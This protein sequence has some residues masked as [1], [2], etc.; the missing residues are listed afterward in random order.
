MFQKF[1]ELVRN[2]FDQMSKHELFTIDVNS[3]EV[4][5]KYL[6]SFPRRNEPDLS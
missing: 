2:Q 6:A 3:D 5:Q 4:W 1:A